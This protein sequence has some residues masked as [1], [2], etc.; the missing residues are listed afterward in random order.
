MTQ[1]FTSFDPAP[2]V[3]RTSFDLDGFETEPVPAAPGQRPATEVDL[4]KVDHRIRTMEGA[5]ACIRG[6]DAGEHIEVRDA[7]DRLVFELDPSGRAILSVPSHLTLRAGGDVEIAAGGALRCRGADEVV[8]ATGDG[9][10]TT[11]SL[12]RQAVEL[13]S[14]VLSVAAK[15]VF[16]RAKS[17][18]RHV[19]D[20]HQIKAGRARTL[21]KDGL[22]VKAGHASIRTVE[23]LKL[24]GE[25]IHLG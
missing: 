22:A 19:D 7:Q 25:A 1:P 17:V 2:A 6:S 20:L 9:D 21:V 24:D 10:T 4:R 16:E 12:R 14:Q 23:E 13:T 18:F 3:S 8:L 5:T 15:H 11:L